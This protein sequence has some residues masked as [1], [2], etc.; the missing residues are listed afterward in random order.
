[1]LILSAGGEHNS[2]LLVLALIKD[3]VTTVSGGIPLHYILNSGSVH[4]A[5]KELILW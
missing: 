1:M 3:T 4:N 2:E 5:F